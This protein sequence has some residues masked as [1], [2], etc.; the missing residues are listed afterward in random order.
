[1]AVFIYLYA[2]LKFLTLKKSSAMK[3]NLFKFLFAAFAVA[4]ISVSCNKEEGYP[5]EAASHIESTGANNES[6]DAVQTEEWD[7]DSKECKTP[8]GK[9]EEKC[10]HK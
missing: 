7:N 3:K 8:R 5:V 1:M 6:S 2:V 9:K 4:A 10:A